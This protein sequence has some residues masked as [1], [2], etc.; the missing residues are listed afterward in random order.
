MEGYIYTQKL[1]SGYFPDHIPLDFNTF[2]KLYDVNDKPRYYQYIVN[3]RY[4]KQ[5]FNSNSKYDRDYLLNNA[6]AFAISKKFWG[7]S[8]PP[9][10]KSYN[11]YVNITRINSISSSTINSAVKPQ[12]D[13]STVL[14]LHCF[15]IQPF[16]NCRV[17]HRSAA[18]DG[19]K[20]MYHK[21]MQTRKQNKI[22]F[23]SV[24]RLRHKYFPGK[25]RSFLRITFY[26]FI[27]L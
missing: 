12:L 2:N 16:C 19:H 14:S 18:V 10:Q 3:G 13:Y 24:F 27:G 7:E 11:K 1:C 6:T 23:S 9:P 20:T 8:I 21:T 25:F 17:S 22:R 26:I 5:V 15:V 4:L